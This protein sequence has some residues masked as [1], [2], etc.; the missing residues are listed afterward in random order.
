MRISIT[1]EKTLI[2]SLQVKIEQDLESKVERIEE[3]KDQT[4]LAFGVGELLTLFSVI[5]GCTEMV[6][7]LME[8]KSN[9]G[10][11][12]QKL[13]LKTALGTTV[14]EISKEIT[15]EELYQQLST[16]IRQP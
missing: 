11:Q 1:G 2:Q 5:Q 3:A 9:F 16:I 14:V 13:Y 15:A 8:L 12:K 4:E 10:S 6:K 7:L